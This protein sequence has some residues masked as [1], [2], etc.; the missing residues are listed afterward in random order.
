MREKFLKALFCTLIELLF[1]ELADE[2]VYCWVVLAVV[3]FYLFEIGDN[4]RINTVG[5]LRILTMAH[6][7]IN[8]IAFVIGFKHSADFIISLH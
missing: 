8:T 6:E 7:A 5:T 1:L 4:F 2:F 3:W